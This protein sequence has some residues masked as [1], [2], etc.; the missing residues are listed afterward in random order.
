M[1]VGGVLGKEVTE[2]DYQMA[3]KEAGFDRGR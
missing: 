3:I 1:G 2:D